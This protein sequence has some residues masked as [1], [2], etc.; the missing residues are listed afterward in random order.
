MLADALRRWGWLRLDRRPAL[1]M[2]VHGFIR[3]SLAFRALTYLNQRC[4]PAADLII[5]SSSKEAGRFVGGR[6]PAVSFIANG[7]RRPA[8][9]DRDHLNAV[10]GAQAA[11]RIAFVGRLSP[12]K[13]PDLFVRMAALVLGQ[14]PDSLFVVIGTGPLEVETRQLAQRL[15][16]AGRVH[17]LGLRDDVGQ[18]L[19]GVDVL[20]CP[21]DTEG[22]PRVVVEAMSVG[23][24]VIA[25]RVGGLPDL[26]TDAVTG[27]LVPPGDV[28]ALAGAVDGLLSN[29]EAARRIAAAAAQ[30]AHA[31]LS[32]DTM[33]RQ[34]A[35]AY[36]AA[37]TLAEA[38]A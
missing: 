18:L 26:V 20:V 23:V 37:C 3:T 2:S 32:I 11:H 28:A 36:A 5:A 8:S 24:P 38:V 10:T 16:V 9:A 34:V 6:F 25:T 35:D 15:G 4:L 21:S 17:F 29:D 31:R 22:T 1:V 7:V 14:H 30:D 33:E 27:L 12:E 13:R 19:H